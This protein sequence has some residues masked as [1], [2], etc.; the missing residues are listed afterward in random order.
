MNHWLGR[1]PDLLLVRAGIEAKDVTVSVAAHS[2]GQ[3]G[4][5]LRYKDEKHYVTAIYREE[6]QDLCTGGIF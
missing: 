2:D 3:T 1:N 6:E 5:A 4:M